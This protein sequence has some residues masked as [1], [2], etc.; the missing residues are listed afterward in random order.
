M[1]VGQLWNAK[2]LYDSA[3]HPT[4]GEKMLII[5]RMSAQVPCNTIITGGMLSFYKTTPSI[6]F[7][8]WVNQTFNAI[9]NYTN[10]S[11]DS[12]SKDQL[13]QAYV[14]ATG[15]ALTAALSLNAI[16]KVN[17]FIINFGY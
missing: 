13:A 6:V 12:V 1:T 4:T 5:G 8:Q 2:Q 3:Y 17:K 14:L 16:T 11:G 10:R 15:G 7:W 9:V